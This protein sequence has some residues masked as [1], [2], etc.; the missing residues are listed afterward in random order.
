M[1][2]EKNK[3]V[4]KLHSEE[5]LRSALRTIDQAQEKVKV[6]HAMRNDWAN[7]N[8]QLYQMRLY[9]TMLNDREEQVLNLSNKVELEKAQASLFMEFLKTTEDDLNKKVASL[10]A[11][12]NKTLNPGRR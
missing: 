3:D 11:S 9:V 1:T 4:Q 2:S 5:Y 8:M 12:L 6:I 7:S 10:R